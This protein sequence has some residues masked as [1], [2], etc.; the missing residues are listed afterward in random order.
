MEAKDL[1]FKEK[2]EN[3]GK[4]VKGLKKGNFTE[5]CEKNGF[6]GGGNPQCIEKALKEAERTGDKLLKKRAVLARTFAGMRKRKMQ[7][8]EMRVNKKEIV[9]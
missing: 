8:K 9:D 2:K 4:M 7:K 6:Q 3:F 5:Y 1:S